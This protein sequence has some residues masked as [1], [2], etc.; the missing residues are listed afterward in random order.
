MTLDLFMKTLPLVWCRETST[1]P[2]GWDFNHPYVGQSLSSSVLMFQY[3]GGTI[4]K[5]DNDMYFLLLPSGAL[6]QPAFSSVNSKTPLFAT[7]DE[8]FPA[9]LQD[10]FNDDNN[11]RVYIELTRRFRNHLSLADSVYT[12]PLL[13]L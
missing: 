7:F 8:L 5:D 13:K 9:N 6:I 4:Y 12:P 3:F 1:L 10:I 2:Y 11:R